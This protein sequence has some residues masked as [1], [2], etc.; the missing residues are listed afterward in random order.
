MS[1]EEIKESDTFVGAR[2]RLKEAWNEFIKTLGEVLKLDKII[3]IINKG[4][5]EDD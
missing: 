1:E 5:K 3:K 4:I 2:L